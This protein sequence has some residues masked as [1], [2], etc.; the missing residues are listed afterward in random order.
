MCAQRA[1]HAMPV[2]SQHQRCVTWKVQLIQQ[3]SSPQRLRICFKG[4]PAAQKAA[5]PGAFLTYKKGSMPGLAPLT[6]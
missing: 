2:C 5:A 1:H 6:C 4:R 3:H